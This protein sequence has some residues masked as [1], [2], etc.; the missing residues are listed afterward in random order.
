MQYG[1]IT[2]RHALGAA[3]DREIDLGSS[4]LGA[5]V[6]VSGHLQ[7]TER[8]GLQTELFLFGSLQ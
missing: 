6:L 4:R 1:K 3:A 5:I 7:L 2:Y 8:V